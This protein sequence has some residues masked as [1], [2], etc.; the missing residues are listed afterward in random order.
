MKI[1]PVQCPR[2]GWGQSL[3]SPPGLIFGYNAPVYRCERNRC[4]ELFI[5]VL[6]VQ[7]NP[8]QVTM[9]DQLWLPQPRPVIYKQVL[10]RIKDLLPEDREALTALYRLTHSRW[11][12]RS[13][14]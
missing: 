2:C 14:A 4:H 9:I 3:A 8:A 10:E 11:V 5:V 13:A 1:N 7:R 12:E 6:F